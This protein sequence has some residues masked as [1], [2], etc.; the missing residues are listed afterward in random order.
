MILKI[1]KEIK[2][3]GIVYTITVKDMEELC[4]LIDRSKDTILIGKNISSGQKEFAFWHEIIHAWNGELDD[5]TVDTIAQM[6]HQITT[7][8]KLF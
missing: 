3:G 1:P 8:N 2:I 6:I 5:V 7:D 4:G